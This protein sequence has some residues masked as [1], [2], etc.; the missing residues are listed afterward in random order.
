MWLIIVG[1]L[2]TT[3]MPS[4]THECYVYVRMCMYNIRYLNYILAKGKVDIYWTI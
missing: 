3:H 4:Y 2:E 1:I